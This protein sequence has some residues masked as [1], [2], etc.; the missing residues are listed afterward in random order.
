MGQSPA[1][2]ESDAFQR[3]TR[4]PSRRRSRAAAGHRLLARGRRQPPLPR[5]RGAGVDTR[6]RRRTGE[7][8]RGGRPADRA[9]GP[10]LAPFQDDLPRPCCAGCG[11]RHPVDPCRR[12]PRWSAEL[13]AAS[14]LAGAGWVVARAARPLPGACQPRCGGVGPQPAS[15]RG[16]RRR[17]VGGARSVRSVQVRARPDCAA[18]REIRRPALT[19][20]DQMSGSGPRRDRP[21]AAASLEAAARSKSG[22]PWLHPVEP[23]VSCSTARSAY[24]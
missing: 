18:R 23:G 21:T 24:S 4:L 14:E 19:A 5:S 6:Y 15:R 17:P 8:R 20:I 7:R 22:L 10:T 3:M 13:P 12:R 11:R 9:A 16:P 1:S 2:R